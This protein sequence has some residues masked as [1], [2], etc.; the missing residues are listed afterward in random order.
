M[1]ASVPIFHYITRTC[2]ISQRITANGFVPAVGTVPSNFFALWFTNQSAFIWL[3]SSNYS[4]VSVPGYSDL[5][6]L[7]DE[8]KIAAIQIQIIAG[9]N[10]NVPGVSGTGAT[11]SGIICMA[12]DYN[13]KN[14]PT[15]IGDVQQYADSRNIRLA[16]NF[17]H[18]EVLRPKFLTYSLD[19]AGAA[20]ASSPKSDFIRS[21]LDI[22]HF[23]KKGCVLQNVP[24]EMYALFTFKYKFIC[25]IQK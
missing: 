25:K 6:A 23:G 19:S 15:A 10:P 5:A 20:I 8:V 9:N 2:S 4:T 7:F 21:N 17:I 3:N 1:S 16:N 13:D 11:G 18:T 24:G 14:A 22:E 12:T